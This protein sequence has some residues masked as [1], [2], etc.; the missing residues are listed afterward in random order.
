MS[1]KLPSLEEIVDLLPNVVLMTDGH[2]N[3]LSVNKGFEDTFGYPVA[4]ALGQHILAFVAEEDQPATIQNALLVVQGIAPSYF[5]NRFI[6]KNGDLVDVQWSS[7][8][9]ADYNICIGIGNQ[10]TELRNMERK[11]EHLANHD[12]LTGLPNRYHL[13]REMDEAIDCAI[14]SDLGLAVLFLDLD[15]FKAANDLH[16][17]ESGDQLLCTVAQKLRQ[18]LRKGD[19]IARVGGDEFVAV[20]PGCATRH[21]AELVANSLRVRLTSLYADGDAV[22][23][24]DVSIGIACFPMDGTT[25]DDLLRHA[26][27]AMYAAKALNRLERPTPSTADPEKA[28]AG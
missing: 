5:R 4:E 9:L 6:H 14:R 1:I 25:S 22:I 21:S 7:R 2:G 17:H 20:L 18:G 23:P 8:W 12:S 15:G 26:D 3:L 24:L 19:F 16:G 11:L 27:T 13:H 10:V 28:G